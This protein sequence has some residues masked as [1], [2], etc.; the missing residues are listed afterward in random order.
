MFPCVSDLLQSK[1]VVQLECQGQMHCC[2]HDSV[3]LAVGFFFFFFFFLRKG[4]FCGETLMSSF[5]DF[6]F[7][8]PGDI[9]TNSEINSLVELNNQHAYRPYYV[10]INTV[11]SSL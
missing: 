9:E 3:S 10:V 4:E 7:S 8:R 6:H 11:Y 1:L 2:G 5:F